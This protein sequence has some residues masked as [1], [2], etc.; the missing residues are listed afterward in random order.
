MKAQRRDIAKKGGS[1][2]LVFNT[3]AKGTEDLSMNLATKN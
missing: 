2:A 3:A 1:D